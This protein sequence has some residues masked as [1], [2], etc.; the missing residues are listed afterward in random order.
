[1]TR[2]DALRLVVADDETLFR[3]GLTMIIDSEPNLTVVAEAAD[4][5]EAVDAVRAHRPD[6]VL[7]DIQM[8]R[9]DG[10]A[11]TAAIV[12]LN[13]PT[14]VLVLTTFGRDELVYEALR[15][16]ASG[17]LLKTLP[18]ARLIEAVKSVADGDAL[19]APTLTRRLIEDWVRRPRPNAH[20]AR[21]AGLTDREHEVLVLIGHGLSNKEIATELNLSESTVKTH[22]TR[23]LAKTGSRDRVQAVV[24]AYETGRITAGQQ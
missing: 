3:S 19:L 2:Q 6:V 8:P 9:L 15:A 20:D 1:M 23:V 22:V 12:N 24:L 7:M 21:L 14:R 18:P 4:G 16:G 13:L 11:A 5:R 17:Y 10:I